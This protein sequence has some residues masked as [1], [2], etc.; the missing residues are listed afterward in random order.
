MWYQDETACDVR[1]AP[2]R[3][4]RQSARPPQTPPICSSPLHAAPLPLPQSF[5]FAV[6]G[7]QPHPQQSGGPTPRFGSVAEAAGASQSHCRGKRPAGAAAAAPDPARPA[8]DAP[9][10]PA[11]APMPSGKR[12]KSGSASGGGTPAPGGTPRKQARPQAQRP[13][14]D[15]PQGGPSAPRPPG[16]VPEKLGE[17]PLRLIIIGHN[18][19]DHAWRSGHFYSNP[20]NR[21]WP[22]LR[23][24]GE[25]AAQGAEGGCNLPPPMGGP[26]GWFP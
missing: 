17:Q 3:R 2:P 21:M 25:G 16:G 11:A 7:K 10:G 20:A 4:C 22:L 15:R 12:A 18:P 9:A 26:S 1:A 6:G 24:C 23:R 13:K 5:R 19:S 8:A 14:G